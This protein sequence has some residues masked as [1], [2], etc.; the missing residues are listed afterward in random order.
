MRSLIVNAD[1]FGLSEGTNRAIFEA[2][3]SGIVTSTT[4]LVNGRAFRRGAN[5]LSSYPA[6]GVG[7]HLNLT[8]GETISERTTTLTDANRKFFPRHE[9]FRRVT[10]RQISS[11]DIL[12]E[13]SAQIA[14]FRNL[15]GR[16]PTHLD[17][18]QNVYL[19]PWIFKAVLSVARSLGCPIRLH[20]ERLF[21][22]LNPK[23]RRT[24]RIARFLLGVAYYQWAQ[25]SHVRTP[26]YH[27]YLNH[28]FSDHMVDRGV[29]T[30]VLNRHL[31]CLPKGISELMVHPA[32]FDQELVQLVRGERLMALQRQEEFFMLC[33]P[34]LKEQVTANDVRLS[35]FGDLT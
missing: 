13:F 10:R 7:V 29:L 32:F 16:C 3:C 21:P 25:A 1:E 23:G 14:H 12:E 6:L 2:H 22:P 24:R 35:H 18:H 26:D 30:K 31:A 28:Y 17:S 5:V 11:E 8:E 33:D 9:L 20:R 19:H 15:T 27:F 4:A 34:N